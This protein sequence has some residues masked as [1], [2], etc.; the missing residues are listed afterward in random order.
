L[1]DAQEDAMITF[2]TSDQKEV[3]RF[4]I[5]QFNG[6]AAT[7]K[8]GEST[9]TGHIRSVREKE[10]SIPPCWT[11]TIIPSA[12]KSTPAILRST[13]RFSSFAEEDFY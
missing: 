5:A 1:R 7:V 9:I 13:P 11:I 12:P 8:S 6:R 4:R 2:E 10:S 3:R